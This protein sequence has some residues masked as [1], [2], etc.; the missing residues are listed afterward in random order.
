[1]SLIT[2][3]HGNVEHATNNT[4]ARY[5]REFL[6]RH[7][8]EWTTLTNKRIIEDT[9]YDFVHRAS[10]PTGYMS[11]E[12]MAYPEYGSSKDHWFNPRILCRAIMDTNLPMLYN[13]QQFIEIFYTSAT[14]VRVTKPQNQELKRSVNKQLTIEKYDKYGWYFNNYGVAAEPGKGFPLKHVVPVFYTTYEQ[15]LLTV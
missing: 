10:K 8:D 12:V 3:V 4:H 1:M 2:K 13:E 14:T 6:L 15:T 5:A 9:F 7:Q 11:F